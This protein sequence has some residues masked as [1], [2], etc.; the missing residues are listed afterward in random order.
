MDALI[1]ATFAV[2]MS[3]ALG[4]FKAVDKADKL[5]SCVALLA[6]VDDALVAADEVSVCAA[7]FSDASLTAAIWLVLLESIFTM[8][9]PDDVILLSEDGCK[10]FTVP[11]PPTYR[12]Q[13]HLPARPL[14][15]RLSFNC[16]N[17]QQVCGRPHKRLKPPF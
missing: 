8:V 14:L 4:V 16:N 17:L 15:A 3:D 1:D 11:Y 5:T 7:R 10:N 2:S 12:F 9:F 13:P 6:D